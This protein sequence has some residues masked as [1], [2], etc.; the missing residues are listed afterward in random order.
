MTS[1][2]PLHVLQSGWDDTFKSSPT[3]FAP[4]PPTAKPPTLRLDMSTMRAERH[5]PAPS[6]ADS[7]ATFAA[8]TLHYVGS[9]T[10]RRALT[11]GLAPGLQAA[12]APAPT[13]SRPVSQ[14][15]LAPRKPSDGALSTISGLSESLLSSSAWPEPPRTLPMSPTAPFSSAAGIPVVADLG[16]PLGAFDAPPRVFRIGDGRPGTPV[17]RPLR[18]VAPKRSFRYLRGPERERG[19]G[20]AFASGEGIYMTVVK[21]VV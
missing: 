12:H 9:P 20:D 6:D 17:V 10:G 18:A 3:F 13:P 2:S 14:L 21:E 5:S 16:V 4:P 1:A 15:S 8:S 19:K 11:A 7:D